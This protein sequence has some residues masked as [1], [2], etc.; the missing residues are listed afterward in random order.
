ML[1]EGCGQE[2]DPDHP[3]PVGVGDT[4]PG[5]GRGWDEG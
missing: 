5:S 1:W 2:M 3:Q 4:N